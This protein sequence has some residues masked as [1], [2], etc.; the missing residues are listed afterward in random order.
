[1]EI[2]NMK[3]IL[4]IIKEKEMEKLLKKMANIILDNLKIIYQMLKE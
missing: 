3:V 1:M 4:L 2:L